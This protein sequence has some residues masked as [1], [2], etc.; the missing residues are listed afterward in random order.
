MAPDTQRIEATE[1][2]PERKKWVSPSLPF[3]KTARLTQG[4][5]GCGESR[6]SGAGRGAGKHAGGN[7]CGALCAYFLPQTGGWVGG[8]SSALAIGRNKPQRSLFL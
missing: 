1:I 7:T 8:L 4:S 5:A 6:M 3:G 2:S